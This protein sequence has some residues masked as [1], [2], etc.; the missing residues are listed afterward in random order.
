MQGPKEQITSPN[1]CRAGQAVTKKIV[2]AGKQRVLESS[3]PSDAGFSSLGLKNNE[4]HRGPDFTSFIRRNQKYYFYMKYQ[5][6]VS[7]D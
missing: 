3:L 2:R 4:R 1:A 5:D 7:D 6:L